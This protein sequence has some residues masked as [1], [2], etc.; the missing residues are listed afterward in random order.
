MLPL[1]SQVGHLLAVCLWASYLNSLSLSFIIFN[2]VMLIV[3]LSV[4]CCGDYWIKKY[5]PL[6]TV[7]CK[8]VACK[9]LLLL[10]ICVCLEKVHILSSFLNYSEVYVD[11]FCLQHF[12]D[13]SPLSSCIYCCG[14]EACCHYDCLSKN[15]FSL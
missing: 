5:K 10:L 7:P 4:G 9:H 11:H 15:L 13:I 14:W 1:E 3:S 6:R 12:H 2:M 8:I